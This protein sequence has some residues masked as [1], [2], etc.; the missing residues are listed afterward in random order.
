MKTQN[1]ILDALK[2]SFQDYDNMRF[3]KYMQYCLLLVEFGYPLQHTV[4]SATLYKW[5]CQNWAL[6]VEFQFLSDNKDYLNSGL[7][8]PVTFQEILTSYSDDINE[9]YCKPI[10]KEIKNQEKSQIQN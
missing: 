9:Y 7:E 3:S 8:D 1:K 10:L 4:Q 6:K 2:M 5:Y